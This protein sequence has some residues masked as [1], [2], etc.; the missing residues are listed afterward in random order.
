MSKWLPINWISIKNLDCTLLYN[1]HFSISVITTTLLIK[2]SVEFNYIKLERSNTFHSL[3]IRFGCRTAFTHV[4]I[5]STD[6]E[7]EIQYVMCVSFD[8]NDIL[9]NMKTNS[10]HLHIYTIHLV[11][12]IYKSI[13][14]KCI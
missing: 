6:I 11:A 1:V 12:H 10:I 7:P 8:I 9:L 14:S 4:T 13:T 3:T 5:N 2:V